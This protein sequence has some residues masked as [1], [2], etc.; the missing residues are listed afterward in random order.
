MGVS[1]SGFGSGAKRWSRP[2]IAAVL[3]ASSVGLL[4]VAAMLG[5]A[6][7]PKADLPAILRAGELGL[8]RGPLRA[9]AP[10]EARFIASRLGSSLGFPAADPA[11]AV[12]RRDDE[13][14]LAATWG[15]ERR[16]ERHELTNDSDAD[17]WTIASVP[18]TAKTDTTGATRRAEDPSDCSAVG[19][20]VWY[21]YPAEQ[22]AGLVAYT[23]GTDHATVVGVFERTASGFMAVGCDTDAGGNSLVTFAAK[24]GRTYFFQV[25][26]PAGGGNLVFN[27]DP[28]GTVRRATIGARSEPPDDLSFDASVSADGRYVA[29]A[30]YARNLAAGD[31]PEDQ[32]CYARKTPPDVDVAQPLDTVAP[33]CRAV[34]LRDL[35][36][37]S[38]ELVSVANDG[39]PA[40]SHSGEQFVSADGRYIVFESTA[41]NLTA[42]D[43]VGSD[44]F[45]RD[46]VAR[47][48][49]R[50][51]AV[52]G[53][54]ESDSGPFLA[55]ISADGRYVGFQTSSALVDDDHNNVFDVY[56]YDRWTKRT[57]RV[58]VSSEGREASPT[59]QRTPA[60]AAGFVTSPGFVDL[61]PFLSAAGRYVVFRSNATDLVPGDRNGTWDTFIRDRLAGTTER[62]SVSSDGSEGDG[63]SGYNWRAGVPTVSDDGRFVVFTS[64][65]TNLAAGDRNEMWDVFMRD[66]VTGRTTRLSEAWDAPALRGQLVFA[67]TI[68]GD[69]RFVAWE[70]SNQAAAVTALTVEETADMYRFDTAT[71]TLTLVTV[72]PNG[73]DSHGQLGTISSHGH[74]VVFQSKA[75]NLAGE[76]N[77]Q[78]N[79]FVY[80]FPDTR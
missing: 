31:G 60:P 18:F 13:R 47:R 41:S 66:R 40:N 12:R 65:A 64:A 68:S 38:T 32:P 11:A 79:I 36:R 5:I 72:A 57:E 55:S 76:T 49:E 16:V 62:V 8:G 56:V 27:L 61:S 58:S 35:H 44:L 43:A 29:F 51:P 69:G 75:S 73:A 19:G 15:V 67:P 46:R 9:V 28:V 50:I 1:T 37:N 3:V 80:E 59:D 14:P 42:D 26:A 2:V 33:T 25:A 22:D 53:V 20:T 52:R 7:S 6:L 34:W 39:S 77:E 21:R 78:W 45:I 4:V 48:T 17:A 24:A 74:H 63:P 30:S 23:F 54:T 70:S 71:S 10:L